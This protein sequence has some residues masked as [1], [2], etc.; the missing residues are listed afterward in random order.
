VEISTKVKKKSKRKKKVGLGTTEAGNDTPDVSGL[1][2]QSPSSHL[3][4]RLMIF[5]DD[6][7][8]PSGT[9]T[10]VLSGVCQYPVLGVKFHLYS[11]L[12]T[13]TPQPQGKPKK[14]KKQKKP[15]T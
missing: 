14:K 3:F 10:P 7:L 4:L 15:E 2:M 9:G 1:G 13:A 5:V 6:S 12:C 11:H 8:P